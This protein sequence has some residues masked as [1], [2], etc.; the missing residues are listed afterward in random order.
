MIV[1]M[2]CALIVKNQCLIFAPLPSTRDQQAL[3]VEE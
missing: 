3:G 1:F 2:F